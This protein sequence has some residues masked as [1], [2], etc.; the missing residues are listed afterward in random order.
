MFISKFVFKQVQSGRTALLL[1]VQR[2]GVN[3]GTL[4]NWSCSM[5]S[6][7]ME[8][9]SAHHQKF[10]ILFFQILNR[11]PLSR[12]YVRG[13]L[14]YL[15]SCLLFVF[16]YNGSDAGSSVAKR[17]VELESATELQQPAKWPK[18]PNTSSKQISNGRTDCFRCW[19][20]YFHCHEAAVSGKNI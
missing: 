2:S 10:T 16:A 7:K 8:S 20:V 18:A 14:L 9:F 1:G 15:V 3:S 5:A 4:Q 11:K 19:Y 17:C 13:A 12:Q 6:M